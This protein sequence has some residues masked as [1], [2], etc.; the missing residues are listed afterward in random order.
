LAA[1][2][3]VGPSHRQKNDFS[4][5][6][7]LLQ[8][9]SSAAAFKRGLGLLFGDLSQS[10]DFLAALVVQFYFSSSARH[11]PFFST[12]AMS[13]LPSFEIMQEPFT[14]FSRRSLGSYR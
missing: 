9:L 8:I 1:R 4:P 13:A 10:F 14:F 12:S 7:G 6:T 5:L 11:S 2:A 3:W